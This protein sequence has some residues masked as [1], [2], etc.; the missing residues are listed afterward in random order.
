MTRCQNQWLPTPLR[1]T[2]HL[3]I[4]F[5]GRRRFKATRWL[6]L[7]DCTRPTL[8][9]SSQAV[10]TVQAACIAIW[11]QYALFRLDQVQRNT[12]SEN[13]RYTG[14]RFGNWTFRSFAPLSIHPMDVLPPRRLPPLPFAMLP[15]YW[16]KTQAAED[17]TSW[18]RSVQG[19]TDENRIEVNGKDGKPKAVI[20]SAVSLCV[21]VC[22]LCSDWSLTSCVFSFHSVI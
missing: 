14:F 13:I 2:V 8:P 20:I 7:A 19:W 6:A 21:C 16:V 15:A 4:N 1:P 17:E 5:N 10:H 12:A 18:G 3:L 9:P 22:V 11:V